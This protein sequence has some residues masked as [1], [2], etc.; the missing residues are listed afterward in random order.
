MTHADSRIRNQE[1][2]QLAAEG[3]DRKDLAKLHGVSVGYVYSLCRHLGLPNR[4]QYARKERAID[5]SKSNNDIARELGV[6]RQRVFQL[7]K[8]HDR[9]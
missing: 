8:R 6:S 7:R 9:N 2:V 5:W 4:R 1:I 3:A